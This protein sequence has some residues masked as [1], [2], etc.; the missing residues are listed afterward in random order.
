MRQIFDDFRA[1]LWHDFLRLA[2]CVR[3]VLGVAF[4]VVL[5]G[6]IAIPIA[7]G[8]RTFWLKMSGAPVNCDCDKTY[9]LTEVEKGRLL[10]LLGQD[11]HSIAPSSSADDQKRETEAGRPTTAPT[12][13][14]P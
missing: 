4:L 13:K 6:L 14:T 5:V 7:A 1:A 12:Q 8:A 10:K 3:V 9:K 2:F 11:A